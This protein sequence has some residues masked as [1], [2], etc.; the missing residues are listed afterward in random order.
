MLKTSGEG[1]RAA[2]CSMNGIGSFP[3]ESFLYIIKQLD[4]THDYVPVHIKSSHLCVIYFT[5]CHIVSMLVHDGPC[6]RNT[7][8][9]LAQRRGCRWYESIY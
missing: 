8:L 2:C 9:V 3:V 5:L 7:H 6:Y 4:S 1:L